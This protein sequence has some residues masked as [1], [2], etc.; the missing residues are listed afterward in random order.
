M[1]TISKLAL[2][3]RSGGKNT[4]GKNTVGKNNG[5]YFCEQLVKY[6]IIPVVN[7]GMETMELWS[8]AGPIPSNTFWVWNVPGKAGF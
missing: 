1:L 3:G 7:Q 2:P 4:V 8:A 6:G 5:I